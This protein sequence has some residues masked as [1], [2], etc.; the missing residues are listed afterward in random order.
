MRGLFIDDVRRRKSEKRGGVFEIT[1]L[2]ADYA[3]KASDPHVLI[4][5]GDALDEL[6]KVEAELWEK[7]LYL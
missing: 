1:S 2:G 4:H 5:I 3:D 6:A 7:D